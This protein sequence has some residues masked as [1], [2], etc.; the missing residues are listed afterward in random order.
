MTYKATV[1]GPTA[2][3]VSDFRFWLFFSSAD[4]V[5]FFSPVVRRF[6]FFFF[7]GGVGWGCDRHI[8]GRQ[9]HAEKYSCRLFGMTET[10]ILPGFHGNLFLELDAT[11]NVSHNIP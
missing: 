8:V 11:A 3:V 4:Q 6:F 10:C 7:F 1:D 9:W 2:D 5:I